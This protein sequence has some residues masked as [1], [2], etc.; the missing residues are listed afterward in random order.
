MGPLVV[1]AAALLPCLLAQAVTVTVGDRSEVRERIQDQFKRTDLE[2]RPFVR[3]GFA[4][5]RTVLTLGYN[6]SLTELSVGTTDAQ[7]LVYHTASAAIHILLILALVSLV[8]HFVRGVS[9][10]PVV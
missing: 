6:P 9:N 8:L 5:H 2:T 3:F 1:P 4:T 7:F 10:R